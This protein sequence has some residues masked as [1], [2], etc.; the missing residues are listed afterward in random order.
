[1]T[2]E[3]H[4]SYWV[5]IS[6]IESGDNPRLGAVVPNGL[7]AILSS[8]NAELACLRK[9]VFID[10]LL[11][12]HFL[13]RP[14]WIVFLVVFI[15]GLTWALTTNEAWEDFYITYRASKNLAEGKGL[16][17]TEGER[18]HSFTSPLGALLP[19][20]SYVLTGRSSDQAAL[21]IYRIMCFTALG[22][23][24][25]LLWKI[26][27]GIFPS[28]A[29]A[30]FLVAWL[31]TD[32]KT[33]S[34]TANGME[35]AFVLLFFSWALWAIF[36]SPDK[37]NAWHLGLAWGGLMW[38]RPDSCIYIA[39][40]AVGVLLFAPSEGLSFLNARAKWL[41]KIAF[42]GTLCAIVY[43][44]WFVWAWHYYGTPVPQTITAKGLFVEMS[45]G[46][47]WSALLHFP[48]VILA[49]ESS[50]S[51]NFIFHYGLSGGLPKSVLTFYLVYATI[52]LVLLIL[53]KVRWETRVAA[54]L[55]V[56][57]HYYLTVVTGPS[58]WYVPQVTLLG[59]VALALGFGQLQE[60][61][62]RRNAD[63]NPSGA[64]RALRAVVLTAAVLLAVAEGVQSVFL[65]RQAYMAR[66][67]VEEPVRGAVG[68]WLHETA[69]SSRE[70]VLLEP[71]GYIG[72]YS[73][74][75]MLDFPGLCSPEMTAARKLAESKSYPFC[76]GELSEILRPDWLVLRPFERDQINRY[77]TRILTQDYEL[78][79]VFDGRENIR[80]ASFVPLR[81][82]LDYNAVFE[83]Y[84]RRKP[85]ER[86]PGPFVPVFFP[87]KLDAFTTKKAAYA[88]ETS[89]LAIKAH[90][91]SDLVWPVPA[92]AHSLRGGFGIF[93][94]AYANPPNST[95]GAEFTIDY[96]KTD[97]SRTTLLKRTL[98][99]T[100]AGDDRGSQQFNLLFPTAG[101]GQIEFTISTGAHGNGSFDWTY[102]HDLRAGFP[103]R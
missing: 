102:W 48:S 96:V 31:A 43:L 49:G 37:R 58:P 9:T 42:A 30:A 8:G 62:A 75:K 6:R 82:F 35:T 1:V 73:G 3:G 19:A 72:F 24:A 74:L 77:Q 87:L 84:K 100:T 11:L 10:P 91:P 98:N 59:L 46:H 15:T 12:M 34:Y 61:L 56:V 53:P 27:R 64:A 20:V 65:A 41:G 51:S 40:M 69:K 86:P 32:N 89:G 88:V 23:A 4:L 5:K 17:F 80:N 47:L 79:K 66:T 50:F 60:F 2:G 14:A 93:E 68:R 97:G 90:A 28:A 18:V 38:T 29:P 99:P 81:G 71:L 78:V 26:L 22:G 70:S 7:L 25:A 63:N 83:I 67:L 45:A 33:I 95:D 101:S 103:I 85:E 36:T 57:G 13:Q 54:L 76:W 94:G 21:W 52:P 55:C 39:T 44:P 16:V 92:G